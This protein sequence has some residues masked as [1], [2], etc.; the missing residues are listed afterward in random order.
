[1]SYSKLT[2]KISADAMTAC[3]SSQHDTYKGR[4]YGSEKETVSAYSVIAA[5]KSG[6]RE[7]VTCRVY[8]GRSRNSSSVW[9]TVWLRGKNYF[10]SGS[11]QAGGYGYHKESAAVDTALQ[12]AGVKLS[13]SVS[14]TGETQAALE[15]TARA[16]GYSGQLL[17][18]SH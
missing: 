9:A 11:G 15:A 2:A 13:R 18:V 10:G 7:V 8:M 14:G 1:M 4:N 3:A 17:F 12:M 5:T 16:L 6:M